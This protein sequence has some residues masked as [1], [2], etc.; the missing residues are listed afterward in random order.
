MV[1]NV[2]WKFHCSARNPQKWLLTQLDDCQ[3]V[4]QPHEME[5]AQLLMSYL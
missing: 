4:K 1:E 3:H 2:I 5:N